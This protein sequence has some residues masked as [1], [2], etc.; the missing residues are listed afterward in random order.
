[1]AFERIQEQAHTIAGST[2][3]VS[4]DRFTTRFKIKKENE[5]I[6]SALLLFLPFRNADVAINN[7]LFTLNILWFILWQSKLVNTDGIV[8]TELLERRRKK[9]IG[10]FIYFLLLSSIKIGI[11]LFA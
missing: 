4:Y 6:Y 3:V 2:I 7:Q 10:M 9:S 1:M 5:I 11:G 8:I